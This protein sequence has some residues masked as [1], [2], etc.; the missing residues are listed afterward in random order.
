MGTKNPKEKNKKNISIKKISSMKQQ[1]SHPARKAN[2]P[3]GWFTEEDA[4]TIKE[5]VIGRFYNT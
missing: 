3:N 1:K 2:R 5:E 4:K